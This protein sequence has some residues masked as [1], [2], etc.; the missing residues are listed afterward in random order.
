MIGAILAAAALVA[1]S[2][3]T[4]ASAAGDAA[5]VRVHLDCDEC[6]FD[7]VREAV[8]FVDWVRDRQTAQVEVLVTIAKTGGGGTRFDVRFVGRQDF[9]GVDDDAS[10]SAPPAAP[11][12]LVRHGLAHVLSLG[13]VRYAAHS[14]AAQGLGVEFRP[15]ATAAAAGRDPWNLWVFSVG[16]S[17]SFSGQ[18]TEHAESAHATANASRTTELWRITVSG[19]GDY[20]QNRYELAGP[21]P[22]TVES[23]SRYALGNVTLVRGLGDHWSADAVASTGFNDYLN[24]AFSAF[25][26]AAVEW[27]VLPY[28]QATQRQLTFRYAFAEDYFRWKEPTIYGYDDQYLPAESLAGTFQMTEP[29]G[30]ISTTATA[31]HYFPHLSQNEATFSTYVDLKLVKG[32]ALN[33]IGSLAFLH[34]QIYLSAAG[35]TEAEV[36]LQRRQ[37]ATS[38]TYSGLVGFSYSFGSIHNDVVNPRFGGAGQHYYGF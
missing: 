33:L 37:L 3:G 5:R 34:D 29:W 35:A 21:P 4:P 36:L 17:G 11:D 18:Q 25:T 16:L 12:D 14:P 23:I 15:L 38:Y 13:L 10:W 31:L 30:S 1:G 6:D 19:V 2:A 32:L 28:A 26:G 7:F 22:T 20:A 27:S 24:T 9:A 8:D